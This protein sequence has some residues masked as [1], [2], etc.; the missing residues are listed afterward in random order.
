MDKFAS[1]IAFARTVELRSFTAAAEALQLSKTVV[2]QR[3]SALESHLQTRLLQRTT[4]KLSLTEAGKVYYEHCARAIDEMEAA[5]NALTRLHTAPRGH[6]RITAPVTFGRLHLAS[7]IPE[8]LA[9]NPDISIELTL[10]DR[11][12]DLVDEGFDI[13]ISLRA[14]PGQNL[15]ARRLAPI[16]RVLCAAPAYLQRAGMPQHIAELSAHQCL[17]YSWQMEWRFN[18]PEGRSVVQVGSRFRANNVEALREATLQG[19]GIA[20]LPSYVVG[21][22]LSSGQLLPVLPEIAPATAFGDQVSAVF[23]PDRHLLPKV[24]ACIDFLVDRFQPTP[25]WDKASA[26]E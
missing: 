25:Y 12:V 14:N 1:I 18:A 17:A 22:D 7:A 26:D 24:R 15:V 20:L 4:R 6:L 5:T 3:I 2:S 19:L 13:G 16:R 21:P 11:Q 23:L 10:L 8:F 9:A